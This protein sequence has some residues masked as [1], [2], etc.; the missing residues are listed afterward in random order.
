[1]SSAS[2]CMIQSGN[3]ILFVWNISDFIPGIFGVVKPIHRVWPV[4]CFVHGNIN[5][6]ELVLYL[7]ECDS[8]TGK[9]RDQV[10]TF[11]WRD[12]YADWCSRQIANCLRPSTHVTPPNSAKEWMASLRAPPRVQMQLRHAQIDQLCK[13]RHEPDVMIVSPEAAV[14][15]F[16]RRKLK[17]LREIG[18]AL[19]Q[20]AFQTDEPKKRAKAAR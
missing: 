9:E 18:C 1:M 15:V 19:L 12:P 16:V 5:G 7:L 11:I 13:L 20:C 6:V 2:R 14:A 4:E 8:Q 17:N 10:S 3:G